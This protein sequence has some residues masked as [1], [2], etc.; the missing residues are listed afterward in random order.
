MEPLQH[1]IIGVGL[2]DGDRAV[3][4]TSALIGRCVGI[5]RYTLAH[6]LRT[7]ET[8]DELAQSLDLEDHREVV[9]KQLDAAYHSETGWPAGAKFEVVALEGVAGDQLVRLAAQEQVDLVAIGR[10]RHKDQDTLGLAAGRLVHQCPASVLVVPQDAPAELRSVLVPIDF[11]PHSCDALDLARRIARG[12]GAEVVVQHVYRVPPGF[13]K[14]GESFENFAASVRAHAGRRWAEIEANLSPDG[15]PTSVRFDLIPHEAWNCKPVDVI[16]RTAEE[17][18]VDLIVTGG[19]G[20][21]GMARF[22]LGSTSEGILKQTH[23]AVLVVKHK[24][25]NIGLLRAIFG[26]EW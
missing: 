25:E 8:P 11:S 15:P 26:E 13:E 23:R 22:F 14:A 24:N 18:N 2:G 6:V 4:A 19:R 21:S 9:L 10:Q 12:A 3:I 7:A 5:E 17:L 16:V 1:A 20:H